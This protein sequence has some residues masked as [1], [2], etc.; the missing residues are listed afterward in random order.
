MAY[1]QMVSSIV[2]DVKAVSEVV[3]E[4]THTAPSVRISSIIYLMRLSFVAPI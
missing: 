2:H 3:S 4:E 1:G